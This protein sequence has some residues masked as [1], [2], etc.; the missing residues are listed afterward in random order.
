MSCTIV[1]TSGND[2]MQRY[3]D[4]MPVILDGSDRSAWLDG[5]AGVNDLSPISESALR[6]WPVSKRVNRS[7][8]FDDDATLIEEI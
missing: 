7:G 2:W 3:H 5:S 6:E 4:R 1:V 8:V